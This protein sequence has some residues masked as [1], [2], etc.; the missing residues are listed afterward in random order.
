MMEQSKLENFPPLSPQNDKVSE[1]WL[2]DWDGDF[3]VYM[4]AKN[5]KLREQFRKEFETREPCN[6]FAGVTVWVDGDTKPS[7]EEIRELIGLGGGNFET[8]FS[9]HLVTHIVAENLSASKIKELKKYRLNSISVVR[10]QW[11][12]DSFASKRLQP[13]ARYTTPGILDEHQKQLQITDK[14]PSNSH[15]RQ[16]GVKSKSTAPRSTSENPNFVRDFFSQSRLHYIGSFR[17]RYEK[18]LARMIADKDT[19]CQFSFDR[20]KACERVVFHV[21]MDCFFAAVAVAKD[22]SLKNRPIAVCHARQSWQVAESSC[23]ISSANYEAREF[24]IHAGMFVGEARKLAPH[25]VLV[26]YD[27]EAYEKTSEQIYKIFLKFAETV[28][29]V[30]VDEAYLE[31]TGIVLPR[32]FQDKEL[33]CIEDVALELRKQ[34]ERVSG[35]TAS[36]GIGSNKTLARIATKKAKP[37]GQFTIWSSEAIE[38]LS[39]LPVEHLPGVGWITRRRLESMNIFTCQQLR[40]LSLETLER[41]FGRQTAHSL[42]EACRGKD[43]RPVEIYRPPKSVGAEVNWGVRF[44]NSSQGAEKC[45]KFILDIVEVVCERLKAADAKATKLTYKVLRK[46]KDAPPPR[47]YLGCGIVDEFSKSTWF[48]SSDSVLEIGPRCLALHESLNV[49]LD[50]LRG[51]GIHCSGLEYKH[52]LHHHHLGQRDGRLS[53]YFP[54]GEKF[55]QQL[56]IDNCFKTSRLASPGRQEKNVEQST[57]CHEKVTTGSTAPLFPIVEHNASWNEWITKNGWSLEVFLQL[58]NEIQRELLKDIQASK[59]SPLGT[60]KSY[61]VST[62]P[63]SKRRIRSKQKSNATLLLQPTLTQLEDIYQA[64]DQGLSQ[65]IVA[66]EFQKRPIRECLEI[67][68]DVEHSKKPKVQ[69][70]LDYSN[71]ANSVRQE[72]ESWYHC[73]ANHSRKKDTFIELARL[74]R[75]WVKK[76]QRCQQEELRRQHQEAISACIQHE[77]ETRNLYHVQGIYD[78]SY[79]LG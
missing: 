65:I 78:D 34:I 33:C 77:I 9:R 11:V 79:L 17:A 45:K 66:E 54:S 56:R 28:E 16:S 24:G 15:S 12:V 36:I 23:E 62:A 58:P 63:C 20:S 39:L 1:T 40:E 27:F 4:E 61:S 13:V 22:P 18:I 30:S 7:R 41:E 8:Y 3:S 32:Q 25:L 43:D 69:I 37:N 48:P 59:Q 35:C 21:D 55:P 42:Y 51:V 71:M 72:Q 67:L 2:K 46:R 73:L 26:P 53:K 57:M 47:K 44:E 68:E 70:P 60:T 76:M 38:K 74:L 52:D 49:P 31:M 14:E 19:L 6:V 50:E 10:P 5:Y 75:Q 29:A 64:K